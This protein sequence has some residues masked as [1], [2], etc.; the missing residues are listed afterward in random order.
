MVIA[1]LSAQSRNCLDGQIRRQGS[2]ERS[3]E[4]QGAIYALWSWL[5]LIIGSIR[6]WPQECWW[7]DSFYTQQPVL[8][9]N[10]RRRHERTEQPGVRISTVWLLCIWERCTGEWSW[11]DSHRFRRS[12]VESQQPE[13]LL[14]GWS[15]SK[16][17]QSVAVA[18]TQSPVKPRRRFVVQW[19]Q[20]EHARLDGTG[21]Q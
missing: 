14:A 2:A 18:G 7:Q 6:G 9:A 15:G 11:H 4:E 13:P 19:Q 3:E 1:P 20:A 16:R 12:N 5:H 21:E 10:S 17:A 8:L